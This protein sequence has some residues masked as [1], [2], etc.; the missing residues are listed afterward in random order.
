V[1]KPRRLDFFRDLID[2]Q[3]F[4]ENLATAR[5]VPTHDRVIYMRFT[6]RPAGVLNIGAEKT[7]SKLILHF[8]DTRSVRISKEKADHAI[9]ENA[10]DKR[11]DDLSHRERS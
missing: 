11:V 4:F 2:F 8:L 10:I 3:R 5:E 7:G 1:L 6:E 9:F